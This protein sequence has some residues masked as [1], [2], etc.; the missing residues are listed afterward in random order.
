MLPFRKILCPTD[1]SEPSHAALKAASELALHFGSELWF[2]HAVTPAPVMGTGMEPPPVN[3]AL[4]DQEL[5]SSTKKSLEEVITRLELQEVA[6]HQIVLIGDPAD[7]ILRTAEEK[8][9]DLIVITTHGR[10]GLGHFVFGSVAEKVVRLSPCP[11]LTIRSSPAAP[12]S[13][14]GEAGATAKEAEE[15]KTTSAEEMPGK[16]DTYIEKLEAQLK[17]WDVEI[18]HFM[19]KVET[20]KAE[21]KAKYGKQIDEL[22]GKQEAAKKKLTEMRQTGGAAWE[23]LRT[24]MTRSMEELKEAYDRAFSKLKEVKEGAAEKAAKK[25]MAYA[26]KAEAELR[27]WNATIELLKAKANKST[28]EVKVRYLEE[29]ERLQAKQKEA[30][31]KLQ[32]FRDSGGEAWADVRGGMDRALADLKKSLK[33]AISRFK[34]NSET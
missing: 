10:T 8:R 25:K 12:E 13:E 6:T 33:N 11:V 23:G 5:L 7:A 21:V 15:E 1:F 9:P 20:S 32:E 17:E 24:A 27:E 22:K 28:A 31:Q 14:T 18:D 19:E 4:Y 16:A 34:K 26:E 29:I 3:T 2:L 30:K